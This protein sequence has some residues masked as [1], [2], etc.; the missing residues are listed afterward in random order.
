MTVVSRTWGAVLCLLACGAASAQGVSLPPFER[1]Q[2]DNGVVLVL[3]EKHEVPLVGMELMLRGGAITDPD[4]MAGLAALT[5]GLLEKG[6]GDRDAA[7][8][9]EAVAAVGGSLSARGGLEAITISAEFL[10]RDADLMVGLVA[11]MLRRPALE[12][13]EFGKLRERRLNLLLA[14][15]DSGLTSLL[16]KY[17]NAFLFGDHPYGRPVEGSEASL[18]RIRHGDVRDYYREHVGA[19]R[20]VIAIS[21]DF[22]TA[23]MV[24][25]LTTAFGDWAPAAT[26]FEE[27]PAPAPAPGPR[28][29]LVDRPDAGQTYFWLG[30]PGVAIDY[31]GRAALN[32]A[33]TL[34]GGRFTSMLNTALRVESGLTYGAF[35]TLTRPSQPGS[36]AVSSLTPVE[37][38]VAA[39][40]LALDV[41]NRLHTDAIG[42]DML[43]SARN[44]I[45]G[46]FPT[47]LE[48]ARQVAAVLAQIEF[49]GLGRDYVD[50]YGAALDAVD[51]VA[52]AATIGEV[53][54]QAGELV[55]VLL[56]DAER[57]RADVA[58]YGEVTEMPVTDPHFGP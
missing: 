4:G 39:V 2:L 57:I 1:V 46:Q 37:T 26:V 9:A 41:L 28:V 51:A 17:G 15:R 13:S 18:G 40:D 19:D 8:F 25:K 24:A 27:P 6:S 43:A 55:F 36:I 12:A 30:A 14:A 5:A 52:L 35:S 45:L 31:E 56:G 54:P 34:F 53:Y 21:G 10:A 11:D 49:Y 23:P 7:E 47:G 48:T 22:E 16:P 42:E 58:K 44:Y 32:L 33:N 29:L 3:S 38:T 20:L 50:A